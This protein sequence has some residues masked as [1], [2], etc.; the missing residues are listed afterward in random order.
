MDID[1]DDATEFFITTVPN[2]ENH[3]LEELFSEGSGNVNSY[4]K[5]WHQNSSIIYIYMTQTKKTAMYQISFTSHNMFEIFSKYSFPRFI[6][7]ALVESILWLGR[8]AT[9]SLSSCYLL[10]PTKIAFKQ[11]VLRAISSL[12]D[13]ECAVFCNALANCKTFICQ[14]SGM[15]QLSSSERLLLDVDT[16][17]EGGRMYSLCTKVVRNSITYS[18][19]V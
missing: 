8:I 3:V 12:S 14:Q 19:L 17:K 7:L 4:M 5:S 18:V 13:V 6:A 10:G 15:C 2:K 1:H 9:S 16:D 11:P